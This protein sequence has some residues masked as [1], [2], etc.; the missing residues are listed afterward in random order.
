L[1]P[2]IPYNGFLRP[3]LTLF[4]T[5]TTLALL[6]RTYRKSCFPTV[7]WAVCMGY[8][9][10]LLYATLLSRTPSDVRTYRLEPFASLKGAFEMAEGTRLRLQAPQVL[11]GIFLN[12][13]LCVPVGYLL[14]L[15]FIQRGKRMRFWQAICAGAAVSAAIEVMQFVTCLGM[16]ELDDWLLNTMGTALGGL[17]YRKLLPRD[18]R[19]CESN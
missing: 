9:F 6:R 18:A 12:L 14:P 19:E 17:L 1:F 8:I 15:A 16:L 2:L 10:L 5:G 11:E 13:C 4:A 7:L 3:L